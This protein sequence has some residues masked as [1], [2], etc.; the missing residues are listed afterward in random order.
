[1]S[2]LETD[3]SVQRAVEGLAHGILLGPV[4]A[5][6]T[7][8]VGVQLDAVQPVPRT[9]AEDVLPTH[10]HGVLGNKRYRLAVVAD[11]LKLPIHFLVGDVIL[12]GGI[13]ITI[14]C[15]QREVC[16]NGSR[17]GNLCPLAA[18]FAGICRFASQSA[19]GEA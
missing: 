4:D 15:I 14:T 6:G 13:G 17:Q 10:V 5:S 3:T 7:S 16:S 9:D 1:M 2:F 12:K 11:F 19:W 18:A 8:V